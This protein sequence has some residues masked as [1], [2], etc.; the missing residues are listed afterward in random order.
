MI[1]SANGASRLAPMFD[2][3]ACL[4]VE[5]DD[6]KPLLNA[7]QSD[8]AA[9]RKYIA[10]CPSGFG[11]GKELVKLTDVIAEFKE[12]P[13]WSITSAHGLPL[14]LKPPALARR[15]S[16]KTSRLFVLWRAPDDGTRF[17]IGELWCGADRGFA[18]AY[19][20]ELPL[21]LARG[22]SLLPEFPSNST[23]DD[24]YASPYLFASFAQR[25]PSP[26]RPDY[27]QILDSWGVEREDDLLEILSLSGGIQATDRLEL[28]E[29]RAVDDDLSRP[30]QFRIA[31]MRYQ[32]QIALVRVGDRF[33]LRH[34]A[35]NVHDADAV[36]VLGREQTRV[37]FVPRQYS[38]MIR[39]LLEAGRELETTA[40]R[41]L[42][43][44]ADIGRWVVR[45]SVVSP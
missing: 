38:R 2:P 25:I 1:R 29:Y 23:R 19:T 5:L 15:A 43:V 7:P 37:G 18:F 20:E 33:D 44:P 35:R 3:A 10:R 42:A 41:E 13:E 14:D 17:A 27:R 24:P 40:I 36:L 32:D 6:S 11:D 21:A 31:G 9:I 28:A 34:D 22:F 39:R 4:G 12:W 45:V 26:K 30:L 8:S 16:V